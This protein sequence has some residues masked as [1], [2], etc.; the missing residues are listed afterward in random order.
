MVLPAKYALGFRGSIAIPTSP[1]IQ[2]RE[3]C[4]SRIQVKALKRWATE[5]GSM[6]AI[7]CPTRTPDVIRTNFFDSTVGAPDMTMLLAVNTEDHAK[8]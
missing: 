3:T 1:L 4:T 7:F 5:R 2:F 6:R 8:R